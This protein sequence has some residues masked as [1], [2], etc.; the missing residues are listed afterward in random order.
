MKSDKKLGIWMDYSSANLIDLYNHTNQ[1][2]ESKFSPSVKE[3]ILKK[4]EKHMHMKENQMYD[5]YFKEIADEVLKYDYVL[6]FGPTDAKLEFRNSLA[7]DARFKHVRI[8]VASTDKLT[9]SKKRAF[10]KTYFSAY[11]K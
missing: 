6:L 11:I 9:D 3:E 2:I 8:D 5:S 7:K 1:I 4:G 10:V